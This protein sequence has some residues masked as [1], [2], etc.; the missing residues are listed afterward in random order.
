M[1]CLSTGSSLQVA[2]DL[3]STTIN[4]I[5]VNSWVMTQSPNRRTFWDSVVEEF[6][7]SPH[8]GAQLVSAHAII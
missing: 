8:D 2:V 6:V 7:G 1:L 4:L 5:L 3:E